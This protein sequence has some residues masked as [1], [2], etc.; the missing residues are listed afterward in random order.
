MKGCSLFHRIRFKTSSSEGSSGVF[1]SCLPG[2]A[3]DLAALGFG[4]RTS[5]KAPFKCATKPAILPFAPSSAKGRENFH[6]LYKNNYKPMRSTLNYLLPCP[7]VPRADTFCTQNCL[8]NGVWA[9]VS[10]CGPLREMQKKPKKYTADRPKPR[11]MRATARILTGMV[12]PA[13]IG[14]IDTGTA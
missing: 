2:T 12:N 1:I 13:T 11:E 14:G 8:E 5:N 10:A 6:N 4:A 9:L 3:V 7:C